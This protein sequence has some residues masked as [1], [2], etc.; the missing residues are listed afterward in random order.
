M[1]K[2]LFH[3]NLSALYDRFGADAVFITINQAAQYLK[4]DRRTLMA[5]KTFPLKQIKA[6]QLVPVM[7][8]ARWLS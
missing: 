6:R 2:E 3:A 8:L 4:R 7:G 1:E 5:D